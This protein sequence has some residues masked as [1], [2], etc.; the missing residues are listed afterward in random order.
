MSDLTEKQKEKLTNQA[1]FIV[2][3]LHQLGRKLS[4]IGMYELAET[5]ANFGD[6]LEKHA[7][8]VEE[9]LELT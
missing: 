8:T 1:W 2:D 9:D 3:N 6:E 4:D 7:R 5:Y